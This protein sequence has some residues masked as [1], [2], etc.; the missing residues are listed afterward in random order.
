MKNANVNRHE[1]RITENEN[2]MR[3]ARWKTQTQPL[4][5]ATTHSKRRRPTMSDNDLG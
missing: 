1:T 5:E 4:Q 3:R 2:Q